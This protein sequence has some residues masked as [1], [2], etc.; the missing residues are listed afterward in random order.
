[1]F[2]YKFHSYSAA[3]RKAAKAKVNTQSYVETVFV[4]ENLIVFDSSS[5]GLLNT[6]D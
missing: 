1:M 3:E 5:V 6:G 4:R 2:Y